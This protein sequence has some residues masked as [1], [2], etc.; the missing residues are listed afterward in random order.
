MNL[1]FLRHGLSDWPNWNR[2][3][4]ERPLTE[5]GVERLNAEAKTIKQLDLGLE[6]V[7]SSPLVRARQTADI[8]ARELGLKV[9][10]TPLLA[11]GFNKAK[12]AE[13]I[14]SYPLSKA[15][16]FVGHEPDF[17]GAVSALIGGGR[18]VMK[19]GGLA[20]V[21]IESAEHLAGELVWLLAPKVLITLCLVVFSM[22]TAA[23]GSLAQT[24]PTAV[25][26]TATL[27]PPATAVPASATSVP[28]LQSG[29]D[30]PSPAP[31]PTFS[32][33]PSP[34]LPPPTP[35][36][37][38]NVSEAIFYS[39]SFDGQSGWFWTFSDD[40]ASFEAK[41]GELQVATK[42]GGSWRYVSRDDIVAGD[43]QLR[44]TARTAVCPG[45]DEYGLMYRARYDDQQSIHAYI[46]KLN[47]AGQ[48]RVEKLEIEAVTV[49]KEWEAYPAVKPG[50]P[51]ENSMMIWMAK[52]QFHFYLNDQYLF[53][54]TDATL[55]DGFYGFFVK[56]H[57]NGGGALSFDDLLVREVAQN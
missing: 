40:V 2:P 22:M 3:D 24:P 39:D 48:V 42:Q 38:L 52:D 11:P 9:S 57:S 16:L 51:A 44:L 10:V 35:D 27:A 4:A 17:S 55:A 18:V 14:H 34:T 41:E 13:L 1:Y 46:F 7:L 32:P 54:L 56:S 43:Q 5:E 53:S 20:R 50:A 19:K 36:P 21:D 45:N 29:A 37:N 25:S 15:I 6:V 31:S 33:T 26:F 30:T 49:L 8:I 12:L 28:T 23:C 47:C